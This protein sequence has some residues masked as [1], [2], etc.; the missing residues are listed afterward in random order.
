MARPQ[1]NHLQAV[2]RIY[3]YI[4]GTSDYGI[5][6]RKAAPKLLTGY[7]DSDYARC[8]DTT[9]STTGFMFQWRQG[10]ITWHAKKQPMLTLSSTEAEYRAL[11][12]ATRETVWI[13]TLLADLGMK[14]PLPITIF[15][16]NESCI[17]LVSNPVFHSKT[18]H[19]RTHYHFTR[20]KVAE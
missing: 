6:F 19:I 5:L 13:N 3:Q 11:S 12:D 1:M 2:K 17:K 20:E 16:D 10:P 9:C 15:C 4:S 14:D 7:V 8:L 18:K